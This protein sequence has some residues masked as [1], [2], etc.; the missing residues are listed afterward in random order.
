MSAIEPAS[1]AVE[2]STETVLNLRFGV[3]QR[4]MFI[5]HVFDGIQ[6]LTYPITWRV[7]SAALSEFEQ[8]QARRKQALR[9]S[10][11]QGKAIVGDD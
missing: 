6:Q 11:R 10:E 7:N 9:P 2:R 5:Q 8:M 4:T 1:E 3:Q